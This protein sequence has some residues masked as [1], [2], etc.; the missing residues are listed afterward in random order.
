MRQ[1]G[2]LDVDCDLRSGSGSVRPHCGGG[3]GGGVCLGQAKW[4]GLEGASAR[5]RTPARE[6]SCRSS[7]K[8]SQLSFMGARRKH[9]EYI[10]LWGG[11]VPPDWRTVDKYRTVNR[12]LRAQ[13]LSKRAHKKIHEIRWATEI[14][15]NWTE[16]ARSCARTAPRERPGWVLC[17]L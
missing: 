10:A 14:P 13:Y 6:Q 5:K 9:D 11:S 1:Q 2:S 8:R 16:C 17:A 12:Y 7:W 15:A 3:G 4:V